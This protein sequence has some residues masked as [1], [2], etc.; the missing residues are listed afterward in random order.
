MGTTFYW[1]RNGPKVGVFCLIA[2]LCLASCGDAPGDGPYQATGMKIGEVT[3]TPD[4]VCELK[5]PLGGRRVLQK[6]YGEDL[7]RIC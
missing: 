5:T 7:P 4:G 1:C 6:P 2:L 3:D